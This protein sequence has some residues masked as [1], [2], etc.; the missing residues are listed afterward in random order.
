[1][2]RWRWLGQLAL[3][4][5][6]VW[7][8]GRAVAGQWDA[9]RQAEWEVTIAPGWVAL[10]VGLVLATFA[11]QVESWRTILAGWGQ[12]LTRLG[13][14]R[15]WFL[16]NLGRYIPGKVWSVAGM[17]VLAARQGVAT[18]AAT[19]S[20]VVLQVIGLG[21]ALALVAATL[22]AADTGLRVLI[23]AAVAAGTLALM[24]W[25][26]A[27]RALQ[28]MVPK[29]AELRPLP[30]PAL[31]RGSGLS[32]AGWIS[33]GTSF[34]ALSRGLGQPPLLSVWMAIGVFAL[35]YT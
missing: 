2:T 3:A 8:V 30:L 28:Q 33:Y 18:W 16:A 26:R 6:L 17:I 9:L 1:M 20:A 4:G 34:W 15:I 35:A 14:A 7:F 13:A 24:A 22:P 12:H 5:V 21:A 23:G 29:L 31:L 19:A 32:A 11:L 10:S 25:P 27:I